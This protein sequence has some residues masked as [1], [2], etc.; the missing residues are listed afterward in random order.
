MVLE[1]SYLDGFADS[2]VLLFLLC[3]CYLVSLSF[4]S[5][6]LNEILYPIENYR[7]EELIFNLK[8]FPALQD[9]FQLR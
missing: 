6:A 9:P 5:L 7:L 8:P 4:I 2:L 3:P 1:D